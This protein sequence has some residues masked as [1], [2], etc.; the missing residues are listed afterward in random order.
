MK[1]NLKLKALAAAALLATGISGVS[2]AANTSA[3]FNVDIT[4]TSTCTVS[5]I[6]N[7]AFAYTSFGALANSTGG[8]F[9]VTCTNTLP[10]TFGLQTGTGAPTPPGNASINVTDDAVN[11]AYTLNAPA[12]ATGDATAQ[13]H[14]ISGTMAAGQSGDC[15]GATC[16][17]AA[18]TNRT[19]TLIVNW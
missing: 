9:T 4:L 5:A 11:L 19:H 10:Y 1:S 14:T 16:S 13:G 2:H 7:V 15:A 6:T 17:N 12:G 8:G 3:T 18:A